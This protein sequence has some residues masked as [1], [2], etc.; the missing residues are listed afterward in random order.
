MS[1]KFVI[2]F[3]LVQTLLLGN[4]RPTLLCINS[5][6]TNNEVCKDVMNILTISSKK[7]YDES[8]FDIQS[9]I[10]KQ[11]NKNKD[12]MLIL[13]SEGFTGSLTAVAQT[14]LLPYYRKNIRA[15]ILDNSPALISGI[16]K[17]NNQT[18]HSFCKGIDKLYKKIQNVASYYELANSLSPALQID[19]YYPEVLLL[20]TDNLYKR[21]W[22]Q[23]LEYNNISYSTDNTNTT[24]ISE[25]ILSLSEKKVDNLSS[26]PKY[27]GPILRFHLNKI[28]GKTKKPLTIWHNLHY[29]ES[30]KQTYDVFFEKYSSDNPMLIYVHG[31][32]WSKGDKKQYSSLCKQYANKGFTCVALNYRPLE[33]PNITMKT[34]IKDVKVGIKKVIEQ[35]NKYSANSKKVVIMGD[36]AGAQLIFMALSQLKEQNVKVAVLNSITSNLHQHSKKKQKKLSGIKDSKKRTI[37]LDTYSPLMNLK[38]YST[39]TLA[40]HSLN[41]TTVPPI[42]LKELDVQSVIFN[43]NINAYWVLDAGHPIAPYYKSIQPSYIDIEN[44]IDNFI[45]KNLK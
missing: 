3:I 15:L 12:T 6:M 45:F 27:Y 29:G 44:K 7:P 20:N 17:K 30:I 19:W 31:G 13:Y 37:W 28:L 41:D 16:C 22:I 23:E 36:S 21:I 35:A 10:R 40:I 14:N 25:F 42:H 34:L 8:I 18:K 38:T 39:T 43:N 24:A 5:D 33:L 2:F 4:S 11:I 9:F 32:G 26:E 1:N